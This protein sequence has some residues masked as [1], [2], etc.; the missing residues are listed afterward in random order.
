MLTY[1]STLTIITPAGT[2]K[3]ELIKGERVQLR[4][5]GVEDIDFILLW[6]NDP[7]YTGEF[8][9]LEPVSRGELEEWLPKEKTGQ[10]WYII[11]TTSGEKVGQVVGRYQEDGSVQIGYRVIPTARRRGYCTEAVKTLVAHL[12]DS[13]VKRIEAEANPA[14]KPS[15]RVLEKLGF[16]ETEYKERAVEINGVWLD[17]V[18][19]ELRS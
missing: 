14:N 16:R 17:G 1:P 12:F 4:P 9:P 6:N 8:E 11:E 10:L 19:Y 5:F 2:F 13:G 18:V 3:G 7:E 15:R